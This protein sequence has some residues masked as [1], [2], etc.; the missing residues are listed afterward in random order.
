MKENWDCE[1]DAYVSLESV[2]AGDANA[3]RMG[4]MR[5]GFKEYCP[6]INEN[7][8]PDDDRTDKALAGMIA[9]SCRRCRA[10]ASS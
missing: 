4:G 7:I 5:D 10:T 8:R 6:I 9:S 3:A 1:Y 2:G